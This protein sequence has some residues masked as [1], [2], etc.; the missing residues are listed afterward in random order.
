MNEQKRKDNFIA[1]LKKAKRLKA[2]F[3]I[4]GGSV[5]FIIIVLLI[6]VT[7]VASL[8]PIFMIT[9]MVGGTTAYVQSDVVSD[10]KINGVENWSEEEKKLFKDYEKEKKYFDDDFK[11]YNASSILSNKNEEFDIS[12]P[13]STVHYQGTVNLTVFDEEYFETIFS[14]GTSSLEYKDETNVKNQ[15]TRDFYKKASERTGNTFR[16]Y[17]GTRMLLGNLV[18]NSILF[19]VVEYEEYPDGGSNASAIYSDWN[20]LGKITASSESAARQSYSVSNTISNIT[21]AIRNGE[22]E[23]SNNSDIWLKDNYCY[24]TDLLFDEIFGTRFD[25]SETSVSQYLR[26]TYDASIPIGDLINGREY[27]AVSVNKKMDYELYEQYLKKVYIPYLYI[28]CDDCEY[29]NYSDE[30][31]Q[32]K[33]DAIYDEI[34]QLTNSFK[35]YNDD[36]LLTSSNAQIGGGTAN[37]PGVNYNCF[38]GKPH[39]ATYKGHSGIDIN[40]VPEGTYVYPL[41]EGIVTNINNYNYNC[42]PRGNDTDGYTC[43]HCTSGYGNLVVIQGTAADGNS[44][45]AMYAHLS[46]ITVS[47]GQHVSLD[48]IIGKVGNTGCSTGAHL[49]LELRGDYFSKDTI[50][51]ANSIYNDSSVSSVLCS[52]AKKEM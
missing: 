14:D 30:V 27:I 1:K 24:D 21:G 13:I 46:E 28:N 50:V 8:L 47:V 41:F 48:T 52:R 19:Y 9:T 22:N 15:H 10:L 25:I 12:T 35:K 40:G 11:Y 16:V 26:E 3:A 37:I 43:G 51:Y 34:L 33:T 45:Y 42:P 49:H 38:S 7:S 23:C 36:E 6:F 17:P 31:K 4:S 20:L 5:P 2:L 39:L 44:Y 32:S 29:N 18:S